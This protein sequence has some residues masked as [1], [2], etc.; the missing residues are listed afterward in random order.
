MF[1]LH[2]VVV[3]GSRRAY[4]TTFALLYALWA[5]LFYPNYK[6]VIINYR[7][8]TA[9]EN[10]SLIKNTYMNLPDFLKVPLKWRGE[11]LEYIEFQNGSKISI[12]VPSSN[13]DPNTI[14]RGLNIPL[15]IWDET[16]YVNGAEVIWGAAQPA[17]RSAAEQARK[18][19]YPYGIICTST[20]LGKEGKGKFFYEL[21]SYST[22][23]EELYD[24]ENEKWLSENPEEH[25][26][27]I[28][29]K[30]P[31][32]YDF[33]RIRIHWSDFPWY[34]DEWYEQQKREL[35]YYTSVEGRRR[36]NQELDLLFLGSEFSLFPDEVLS[37]FEPKKPIDTLNLKYGASLKIFQEPKEDDY[38]VIGVDTAKS[39]TG[40]YSAIEIF[41]GATF[42]QIAELKHRFGMVERFAEVLKDVVKIF[43]SQYKIRKL[44]LFIEN[45]SYGN[46]VVES[47]INDTEFDYTPLIYC[48]TRKSGEVVYGITTTGKNKETIINCLYELIT[49]KPQRIKSQDLIN[50]LHTIEKKGQK[51]AAAKGYH[52]DLFMA[53]AFAAYGR[54]ILIKNNELILNEEEEKE[55]NKMMKDTV[56]N[57]LLY[58]PR[59][60]KKEEI[61]ITDEELDDEKL[62]DYVVFV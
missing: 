48:E 43:I 62:D 49:D 29:D 52:D 2:K 1:R 44:K 12:L 19:N 20:P 38:L 33:V 37:S 16:A 36:V 41:D 50:E 39:L 45:N 7:K 13:V 54:N 21:Y 59:T 35:G 61:F 8:E 3:L 40:D 46:Q 32:R 55:F 34:D 10:L 17:L 22:P 56:K 25:L 26:K 14:G 9:K 11:R 4:K 28:L 47:L 53:A 23:I 57:I 42:T 18:N 30:N 31:Y 15:L 27:E 6:V 24:L 5:S 58:D 60:D 51:I